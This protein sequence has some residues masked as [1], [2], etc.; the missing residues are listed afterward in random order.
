MPSPVAGTIQGHFPAF[1][2]HPDV[3]LIVGLLVAAYAI[4][5]TLSGAIVVA[6]GAL[7]GEWPLAAG[8]LTLVA[9]A[10]LRR[11]A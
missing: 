7:F 9:C 1:Q 11:W 4:A 6:F 3:L 5:L 2:P 8:G 10:L